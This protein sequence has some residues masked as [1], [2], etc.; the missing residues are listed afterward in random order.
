MPITT[1]TSREFNQDL[2]KAKRAAQKGPVMVTDRGKPA[3]VLLS[4]NEYEKI[5]GT[6][7]N[8]LDLLAMP[9]AA[10]LDFSPPKLKLHSKPV[11]LT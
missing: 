9:E 6:G 3:L 11:D 4:V 5:T 7:K 1:M 8:I 2:S 10:A